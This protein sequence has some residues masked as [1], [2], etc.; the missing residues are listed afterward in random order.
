MALLEAE[1]REARLDELREQQARHEE[2]AVDP[3]LDEAN[4]KRAATLAAQREA[5]IAALEAEKTDD[6]DDDEPPGNAGGPDDDLPHH[7]PLHERDG[8]PKDRAQ[9]NF[10]DGD[11]RIMVRDGD[12]IVQAF[13][14]QAVVDNAHQIIVAEGVSNQAPDA[15]YFEPMLDRVVRNVA[16]AALSLPTA[17]PIAADTGYFSEGNVA[18]ATRRGF[19]P[20]IAPERSKHRRYELPTDPE[21]DGTDLSEEETVDPPAGCRSAAQA[22]RARGGAGPDPQGSHAGQAADREGRFSLRGLYKVRAEWTLVTLTHNLL[23]AWR[24]GLPPPTPA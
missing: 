8:K 11:S 18:G 15:E 16:A 20:Y 13:N 19:D 17:A 10:T 3:N 23:K 14:A 2:R 5:A 6:S 21:P 1:A 7:R 24:S 4:Q 22:R 12:H 9:R